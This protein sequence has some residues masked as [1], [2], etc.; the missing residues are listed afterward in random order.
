MRFVSLLSQ[1]YLVLRRC[2]LCLC[3]S[4]LE[5]DAGDGV[6]NP[7]EAA[8]EESKWASRTE[9][10][11]LN[12]GEREGDSSSSGLE[13]EPVPQQIREG[14]PDS[15]PVH[16]SVAPSSGHLPSSADKPGGP[17]FTQ[18]QSPPPPQFQTLRSAGQFQGVKPV[19]LCRRELRQI[20][21]LELSLRRSSLGAGVRSVTADSLEVPEE[22]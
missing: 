9:K 3:G 19:K 14:S 10:T 1:K 20:S 5:H 8:S 12:G 22:T 6:L 4:S 17:F 11:K 15:L 21:A 13:T 18:L 7:E 2:L 16:G